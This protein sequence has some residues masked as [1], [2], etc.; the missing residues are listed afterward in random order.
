M[1][2]L[3]GIFLPVMPQ[4]SVIISSGQRRWVWKCFEFVPNTSNF[5]DLTVACITWSLLLGC[6]SFG[7][8]CC[9]VLMGTA[10]SFVGSVGCNSDALR[11]MVLCLPQVLT[12]LTLSDLM[13]VSQNLVTLGQTRS[14]E[15]IDTLA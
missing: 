4:F 9:S 15:S 1:W 3:L 5:Y 8:L 12:Q 11:H 2:Q 6:T 13:P 10:V 14:G 7:D